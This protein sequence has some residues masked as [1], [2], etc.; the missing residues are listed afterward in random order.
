M[1]E[2]VPTDPRTEVQSR[3]LRLPGV[4]CRPHPSRAPAPERCAA[5]AAGHHRRPLRRDPHARVPSARRCRP[6][7]GRALETP[8]S[9]GPGALPAGPAPPAGSAA[10]HAA[11]VAAQGAAPRLL[12]ADLPAPV[13]RQLPVS[14]RRGAAGGDPAWRAGAPGGNAAGRSWAGRRCPA[15]AKAGGHWVAWPPKPPR[16]RA[17]RGALAETGWFGFEQRWLPG[18]DYPPRPGCRHR[19]EGRR[20]LGRGGDALRAQP[21]PGPALSPPHISP[22]GPHCGATFERVPRPPPSERGR[23]R[24]RRSPP[25]RDSKLPWS[26]R[27]LAPSAW[28]GPAR[29]APHLGVRGAERARGSHRGVPRGPGP[30]SGAERGRACA[31]AGPAIARLRA[32]PGRARPGP[33]SRGARWR[34][35]GFAGFLMGRICSGLRF[36]KKFDLWNRRLGEF[37]LDATD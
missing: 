28:P 34:S 35:G 6:A 15:R 2:P 22:R 11:A 12:P 30:A 32:A 19:R 36:K 18:G 9:A 14:A 5:L 33:G 10:H 3:R 27:L 7:P 21:S 31:S 4:P 1:T 16:W 25:G 37:K 8:A 23:T 17:G 13:R 29:P 26:L 24:A 20:A